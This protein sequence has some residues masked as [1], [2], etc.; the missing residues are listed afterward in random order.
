MEM[1][2]C[3]G[4]MSFELV[5]LVAACVLCLIE[6][7]SPATRPV[8]SE[9]I[10]GRPA[11]VTL[12]CLRSRASQDAW[13]K[14]SE[15]SLKRSRYLRLR[16]SLFTSSTVRAPSANGGLYLSARLAYLLHYAAGVPLLRSLVWNVAFLEM[17]FFWSRRSGPYSAPIRI[18]AFRR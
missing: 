9:A 3:E 5:T 16:S 13:K 6:L 4:C 17:A 18:T 2:G 14:R 1:G 12:K 7:L 8:F 15:T 11:L 10:V